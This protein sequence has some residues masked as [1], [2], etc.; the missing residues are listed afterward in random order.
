M[1]I[2]SSRWF[3]SIVAVLLVLVVLYLLGR[4]TVHTEILIAA[5]PGE[6]WSVLVDRP[7]Y[8]DWNPVLVPLEGELREGA[9]LTYLM[10]GPGDQQTE[11]KTRVVVLVEE[12]HLN[13]RG[14]VPGVLTFD[15][16]WRLER[17]DGGTQVTQ[18]EEYRGIGVLF[19]D[20]GWVTPAYEKA[21]Q[22]LRDQV[23][24]VQSYEPK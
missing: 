3:L 15:H 22:G 6:V 19:W 14:G 9:T 13:Q 7:G 21:N 17:V 18:H 5:E 20:P 4:K 2:L 8:R 1:S 24:K 12:E 10:T 23:A 16:H 11:V